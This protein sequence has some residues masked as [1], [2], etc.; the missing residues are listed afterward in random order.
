MSGQELL[1]PVWTHVTGMVPVD[2]DG[3]Y[4]YDSQGHQYID[5]TSG[6]GVTN[7]GHCHPRI[8]RAIQEQAQKL[9]FAQ[10]NIVINPQALALAEELDMVTPDTINRFFFSNS[11]AEAV[12]SAVKLARHATGRRN[13]VVFQGSF[14]GRTAQTM[15]MTTSKT[16][17]RHDYQPLPAGVFVAPFPYAYFY[18]WDEA[19]VVDFCLK[20]LDLLF[21]SQTPVEETAA[22][23]IE[24][25][26]GEGGYVPA[27][28]SFLQA[29][30]KICDE[31]GILLVIDEIQSGFGRSGAFFAFEHADIVPDVI[32]MAK[33]LGSGMP[34]SAIASRTDL[35]DRWKPG[36]HGGTYGGGNA[37]ALAAACETVKVIRDE[38][39]A[40]NAAE[41]GVYLMEKL[42]DLQQKYVFIGDV[43]GRGLMIAT[44]FTREGEPDA[45][46]AKTV[47]KACVDQRLLLLTCGSYGNVVRW[48]P[49]LIVTR[50]QIDDAVAIFAA[51]LKAVVKPA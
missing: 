27:P 35:M 13:I 1:S 18:G 40:Q 29:L 7:T 4:L 17:Y 37:V 20:Q 19:D 45:E 8:V 33:G 47:A 46:A 41:T 51:A 15:A 14:H 16:I 36:S 32:V 28:A 50:D 12:E 30:R 9:I 11:G 39:L 34:V 49:P 31:H 2:A 25:V 38:K 21:K 23:V 3:I 6:I 24:P 42:R 26:M 48:I 43:R 10:M 44:E 22:L 5:F